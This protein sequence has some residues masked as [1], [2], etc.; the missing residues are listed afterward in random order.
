MS[1]FSGFD[2]PLHFPTNF[3]LARDRD[4]VKLRQQ[5]SHLSARQPLVIDN[6]R[7]VFH[8]LF[9]GVSCEFV[10]LVFSV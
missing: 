10:V 9:R 5:A 1:G 6:D 2:Q 3:R 7:L 4:L 8:F